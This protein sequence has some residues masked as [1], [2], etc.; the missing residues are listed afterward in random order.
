MNMLL[1]PTDNYYEDENSIFMAPFYEI[2]KE[3]I[4]D[5]EDIIKWVRQLTDKNWITREHIRFFVERASNHI[6]FVPFG[7]R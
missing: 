3:R 1:Q 5:T 4:K 6:N 7:I 2:E